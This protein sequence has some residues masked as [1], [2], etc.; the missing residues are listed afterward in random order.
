M[1]AGTQCDEEVECLR[2]RRLALRA[3]T[4]RDAPTI[5]TYLADQDVARMLARVPVPYSL[6]DAESFVNDHGSELV[7]A[8]R[9]PADDRLVGLCG[10][11]P[12]ASGKRAEL[13]YWIGRP[14]WGNGYA[15]EAAQ[16]LIDYGFKTLGLERVDVSCRVVNVA[17]RR[18]ISKCGFTFCGAGMMLTAA[19]GRV[20]SE[21]F[22][23]DRSCW[24][25]LKAWG[26]A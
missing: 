15:T 24:K 26:R 20:A 14:H 6:A 1:S 7:L 9:A 3:L 8:I 25:A 2:T 12:D 13:G 21:H 19:N 5:A 22:S 4:P 16:A 18:V 17:S 10:L 23:M 11:N